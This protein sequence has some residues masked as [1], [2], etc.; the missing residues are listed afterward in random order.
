MNSEFF[1]QPL[2]D[3]P[4][5]RS[6]FDSL[7]ARC[8]P[9]FFNRFAAYYQY[10]WHLPANESSYSVYIPE[11]TVR[12]RETNV[13]EALQKIPEDQ[14]KQMRKTI[15]QDIMPGL[16]YGD[17]DSS[18]EEFQD[19]FMISLNNILWRIEKNGISM[20]PSKN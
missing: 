13:V 8:I 19:A 17:P 3:S 15:I 16:V 7:I 4:T 12:K 6:V 14:R 20:N 2:G 11:E 1:L 9:M 18:F 5:R 10:P